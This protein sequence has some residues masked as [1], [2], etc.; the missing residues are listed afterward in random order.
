MMGHFKELAP[1]AGANMTDERSGI[2]GL[3]ETANYWNEQTGVGGTASGS[4]LAKKNVFLRPARLDS[5]L[6]YIT[7]YGLDKTE[8]NGGNVAEIISERF[9]WFE[10]PAMPDNGGEGAPAADNVRSMGGPVN[11]LGIINNGNA[12]YVEAAVDFLKFVLSPKGQNIRYDT[13]LANGYTA[14]MPSLVKDCTIS[15]KIDQ[16]SDRSYTSGCERNPIN[17]FTLGY[18]DGNITVSGSTETLNNRVGTLYSE[19]LLKGK[20]WSSVAAQIQSA[21]EASFGQWAEY[22]GLKYTAFDRDTINRQTNNMKENPVR[23]TQ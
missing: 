18:G 16:A 12:E 10:M 19:Y 8:N 6:D 7:R 2:L 15:Q 1:Y 20:A 4:E 5:V 11:E 21:I 9:G 22:R 3:D 17:T 23:D 13:Y 14:V